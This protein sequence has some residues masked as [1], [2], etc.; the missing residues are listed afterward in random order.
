MCVAV[1]VLSSGPLL[2]ALWL[3]LR[4]GAPLNPGVTAALAAL[5]VSALA[6]VAACVAQP[7]PQNGVTLIW[8]GATIAVL[9][10]IAAATG[11]LVFKWDVRALPARTTG[12]QP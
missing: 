3:M 2:A 9:V 4:R 5:A 11:H 1:I 7:H 10:T 8:H 12:A 6:N